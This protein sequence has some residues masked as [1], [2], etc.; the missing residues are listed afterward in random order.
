MLRKFVLYFIYLRHVG[1]MQNY[2]DTFAQKS[3]CI[4]VATTDAV[5]LR[6]HLI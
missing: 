2:C 1:R 6:S 5:D 3:C 4:T